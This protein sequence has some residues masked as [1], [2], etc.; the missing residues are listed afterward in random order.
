MKKVSLLLLVGFVF[1][2]T[3]CYSQTMESKGVVVAIEQV[4]I[5][6]VKA[7]LED[8]LTGEL[9]K[10]KKIKKEKVAK[11]DH[12]DI[13]KESDSKEVSVRNEK[14]VVEGEVMGETMK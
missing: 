8:E 2:V 3:N 14:V 1:G 5:D 13:R 7:I 12:A 4:S 10:T 11:G 6:E 9:V